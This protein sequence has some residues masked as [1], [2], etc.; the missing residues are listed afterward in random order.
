MVS[1]LLTLNI[2]HTYFSTVSTVEFEQANV[3]WESVSQ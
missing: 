2:F 1:L 3:R